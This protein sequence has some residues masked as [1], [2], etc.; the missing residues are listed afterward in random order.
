VDV[1]PRNQRGKVD[2]EALRQ[3]ALTAVSHRAEY[4]PPRDPKEQALA[5]IV[6][7]VLGVERVGAKDDVF[8]L[9]ADS[10]STV[11]L[12]VAIHDRLGAELKTADLLRAP[13]IE[14]LALQVDA[15]GPGNDI[16]WPLRLEGSGTPFF[17][18]PGGGFAVVELLPLARHVDR[19]IYSFVCRGFDRRALPDRSVER[20]AARCVSALRTVQP[21]GP[22]LIGGFSFGGLVAH[23]MAHQLRSA[24]ET[25][26]L[27]ALLD[28]TWRSAAYRDRVRRFVV[29][30]P[31]SSQ[32]G[33]AVATRLARQV[34]EYVR[35]RIR[36]ATAGIVT[37]PYISQRRVFL[38]LCAR[39]SRRYRP[40][41][42]DGPSLLLRARERDQ[43]GLLDMAHLLTGERRLVDI[44]GSHGAIM[45]EPQV[46]IVAALLGREL[47]TA[48]GGSG[49][50]V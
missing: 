13:T 33:V 44:P 9:G 4:T 26:A 17:C 28:P 36:L 39:M 3:A 22:Y 7:E 20:I 2:R 15:T 19:P 23:E 21:A 29:G 11:E 1:V 10:L 37:R 25:V 35:A 46:A 38:D 49:S 31:E 50:P 8:E 16:V 32:G 14:A 12:L 42:Y 41:P 24:G 18:V 27:L 43:T 30:S 34:D 6:A 47:Q 5:E 40:K 48:D 45:R